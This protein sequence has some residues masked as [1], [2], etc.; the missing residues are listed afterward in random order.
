MKRFFSSFGMAPWGLTIFAVMITAFLLYKSSLNYFFFQDDF[1]EINISKA[2]NV[3]DYLNFF[4]FRND[5]IAY[6]PISLQTYFFTSSQIFG[7]NAGGFRVI[8]FTFLFASYLLL[9]KI[10]EKITKS[11]LIA[12]TTASLWLLSSIHF[13]AITWIAAAYNIIGTSFWFMTSYLFLRYIDS[14]NKKYYL[15]SLIAFLLTIGSF[16]FS[17]TWPAIFGVYY[18]IVLK[19]GFQKSIKTFLPFAI[20]SAIYLVLRLYLIK[21]PQILEYK[22]TFNIDSIKALFWYFLWTFN[23]PEEF[24]KQIVTKLLIFNPKF[25]NEYWQLVV[26]TFGAALVIITLGIITPVIN[27]IR[28]KRSGDLQILLFAAA[29]FVIGISPVLVLPNH[30]FTMYLTLASIGIYFLISYLLVRSGLE[31]LIAPLIIIWILSSLVT[32]SFYRENSWMVESQRF[33]SSFYLQIKQEYPILPHNS[34][35]YYPLTDHR[36]LQA[37]LGNNAIQAIYNDPTLSI[38]Y[39]K[40]SLMEFWRQN[41]HQSKIYIPK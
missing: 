10:I 22:T 30:T 38:Y 17:I 28:K 6:R 12:F 2:H 19:K 8:T 39:N 5:I 27:L 41:P 21:V 37:L 23:I 33:A 31:K 20:I 13:M 14:Q 26:E 40:V 9:A 25:L 34:Q 16:E 18:L 1:F 35:V 7:F 11:K 3:A 4:K 36:Y 15:L 29:W 32:L 24:K